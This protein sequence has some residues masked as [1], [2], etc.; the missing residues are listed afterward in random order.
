M[1]TNDVDFKRL[2]KKDKIE[3]MCSIIDGTCKNKTL[4]EFYKY[5][6]FKDKFFIVNNQGKK[7]FTMFDLMSNYLGRNID[8]NMVNTVFCNYWNIDY[9]DV[10]PAVFTDIRDFI[11]LEWKRLGYN[12]NDDSDLK[13]LYFIIVG[14]K[15][16]ISK[17]IRN[18]CKSNVVCDNLK[19]IL[20]ECNITFDQL[21]QSSY[22][23]S[24]LDC[25][26]EYKL[27]TMYIAYQDRLKKLIINY[28]PKK[29]IIF[30]SIE[31]FS[32]LYDYVKNLLVLSKFII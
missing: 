15:N 1:I 5:I 27:F 11:N 6:N 8:I 19:H 30:N 24:V 28:K 7:I 17:S 14:R 32:S 12:V 16:E 29:K 20:S 3:Y 4:A 9:N 31:T 25:I 26:D 13:L 23:S 2:N 18:N 10:I 21:Y 22:S